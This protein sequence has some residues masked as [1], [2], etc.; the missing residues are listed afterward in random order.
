MGVKVLRFIY[1]ASLMTVLVV[2]A[3]MTAM[4]WLYSYLDFTYLIAKSAGKLEVLDLVRT[5]FFTMQKFLFARYLMSG[6]L[7]AY[8]IVL[9]FLIRKSELVT[10]HFSEFIKEVAQFGRQWF[11]LIR[12]SSFIQRVFAGLLFVLLLVKTI[13]YLQY[14]VQY[15]EAWTYNYFVSNNLLVALS[16]YNNHPLFVVLA[17]LC[18]HLPFSVSVNLRLPVVLF[19]FLSVAAMFAFL[20]RFFPYWVAMAGCYFFAFSGPVTFY[21]LYARGYILLTFFVIVSTYSLFKLWVF[22]NEMVIKRSKWRMIFVLSCILGFYAMPTFVYHFTILSC[23]GLLAAIFNKRMD[24][25]WEMGKS[26]GSIVLGVSLVYMPMLLGT[27]IGLG[28]QVATESN[29]WIWVWQHFSKYIS[30]TWYFLIGTAFHWEYVLIIMLCIFWSY[31]QSNNQRK[32]ITIFSLFSLAMILFAYTL[33]RVFIPERIWTYLAVFLSILFAGIV[34][35]IY[36]RMASNKFRLAIIGFITLCTVC[37]NAYLTHQND[38]I[39]WSYQRD[40]NSKMIANL[41]MLHRVQRYYLNLDYYKPMIEYYHKIEETSIQPVSGNQ[42]SIDF[43]P[44]E[45]QKNYEAVLWDNCITLPEGLSERYDMQF[46]DDEITVWIKKPN[47]NT[48]K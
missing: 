23:F 39:N 29:H 46:S 21:M 20:L 9:P 40:S 25:I 16:V 22:P 34:S 3:T 12:G 19:G 4:L 18:K 28:V 6:L 47:E 37:T 45:L 1:F 38:F 41:F 48:G 17:N 31:R 24:W 32:Q 43:Q 7:L 44:F 42:Q 11:I 5:R 15:D 14:P 30:R 8:A 27:G 13:F 36:S 26:I 35:A 10:V 33:Q 2:L